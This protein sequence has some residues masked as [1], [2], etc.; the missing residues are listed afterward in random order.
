[1]SK[2]ILSIVLALV[3]LLTMGTVAL[4]SVSADLATIPEQ[5]ADTYRYYFYLPE[6]W[7]NDSTATTGNTAGI[8]W[9]EGTDACGSW[10]GYQANKADVDGIYYYD[11]PTDV[12][13]ILWNNFFDGGADVYAPYYKDAVQTR[14]IGTE[15]YD[16]GESDLYPEGTENFDGMI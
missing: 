10:P 2:K 4:V 5:P 7:L 9:W 1:M 6:K 13:T 15:Y 8:Y 11:V 3:M 14:N 12:T 16:A